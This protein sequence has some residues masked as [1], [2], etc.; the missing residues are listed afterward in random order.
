M[1]QLDCNCGLRCWSMWIGLIPQILLQHKRVVSSATSCRQV[2]LLA[3]CCQVFV[4]D[5]PN[6]KMALLIG[7]L[8]NIH[9]NCG[10]HC[11]S[12]WS[13]LIPQILLQHKLSLHVLVYSA[14]ESCCKRC[15]HCD[16]QTMESSAG[17]Q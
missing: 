15:R 4:R 9:C 12:M 10:L 8:S 3:W 11:W 14:A 7:I 13:G 2:Q 17:P 5:A 1:W 16:C 6:N